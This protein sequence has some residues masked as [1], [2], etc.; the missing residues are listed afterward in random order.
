[1]LDRVVLLEKILDDDYF[2]QLGV[3]GAAQP[4]DQSGV[5]GFGGLSDIFGFQSST[6]F[7]PPAEVSEIINSN[8]KRQGDG[9][10]CFIN[11]KFEIH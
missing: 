5:P 7:T 3:G 1:M 2:L 8:S 6:F 9:I 10:L 11:F 4:G